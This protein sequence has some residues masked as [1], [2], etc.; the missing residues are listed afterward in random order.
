[1]EENKKKTFLKSNP[2]N[3]VV[4]EDISMLLD[5]SMMVNLDFQLD[6]F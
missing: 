5:P 1:M 3:Q 6:D 2:R 4:L